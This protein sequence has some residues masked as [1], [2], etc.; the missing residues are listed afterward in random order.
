MGADLATTRH[1]D[2]WIDHVERAHALSHG[3]A[4]RIEESASSP[5]DLAPVLRSLAQGIGAMYDALDARD[6]PA[7]ALSR[8]HGRLWDAAI[9]AA[10]GGLLDEVTSLRDACA[11]LID[12]ERL[13][14]GSPA[15]EGRSALEASRARSRD[16]SRGAERSAAHR[17]E[18]D[19]SQDAERDAARAPRAA[20]REA[21]PVHAID[22]ASLTPSF[23]APP[24]VEATATR[25]SSPLPVPTTF[26][27]LAAAAAKLRDLAE[28]SRAGLTASLQRRAPPQPPLLPSSLPAPRVEPPPGFASAP[29][30]PIS[31]D[32]FLRIWARECFEEIGM[33]GVQRA[34]LPSEDWRAARFLDARLLASIDALAALGPAAIAHV[35]PLAMDAPVPDPLRI[36][37]AS[38]IAGC[39]AGR[40]AL[41]V[42]ERV[43]HR[44]GAGDPVVAQAFGAA[45]KLAPHPLLPRVL[46]GLASAETTRVLATD[47]LGARGWLSAAELPGLAAD[48]D[49]R[50][51]AIALRAMGAMRHGELE[52]LALEAAGDDDVAV[53]AAL[54]EGLLLAASPRAARTARAAAG[55]PLGD[56][57]LIALAIAGDESDAAWLLDRARER[58]TPAAIAAL[59]W[60]GSIGAIPWLID[61]LEAHEAGAV[62]ARGAP[63]AEGRDAAARAL[64]R[65]LGA[66]LVDRVEVMPEALDKL[67]VHD[68][69]PKPSPVRRSLVEMLEEPRDPAPAGSSE[70]LEV[71]STDPAR[72]RAYWTER[73][74]AFDARLRWRRGKPHCA[75]VVLEELDRLPLGR[76][77]R[78]CLVRELAYRTGEFVRGG[79]DDLVATQEKSLLGWAQIVE[80]TR[81]TPGTW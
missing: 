17:P 26:E 79:P 55:G 16:A 60:A 61:R 15:P 67:D 3:V 20:S 32:D 4:S 36:F 29:P 21:L 77:D 43:L 80:R 24:V 31:E 63:D 45:M 52:G 7:S 53:Q 49:P 75:S 78:L 73:R 48:A 47:L 54:L 6:D 22:R 34:P 71:T 72:W 76:E 57:A 39:M 30:D 38:L 1:D 37:A 74:S 18:R 65:L 28:A 56:G 40:D 41:G 44:F 25:A 19:A 62:E 23:R 81:E 33:L 42:A 51:R 35:E 58:P 10:H 13:V 69:D 2:A 8:A 12:A 64:D 5:V 50:V 68:P 46:R 66:R 27:E 59:G 11:S 9:G 70:T 14:P